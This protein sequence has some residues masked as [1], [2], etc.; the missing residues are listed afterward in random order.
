MTDENG[1]Y[2]TAALDAM[3]EVQEVILDEVLDHFLKKIKSVGSNDDRL[4]LFQ[5]ILIFSGC[6]YWPSIKGIGLKTAVK[7]F[8]EK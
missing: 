2:S 4:A 3:A 8:Q 1:E 7:F 5:K 6:D